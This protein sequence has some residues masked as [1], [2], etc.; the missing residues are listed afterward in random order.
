MSARKKHQPEETVVSVFNDA[1][2][3]RDVE[4]RFL[5][6][7]DRHGYPEISKFPLRLALEEALVNA[8]KH[9]HR[10]L[11]DKPVSVSWRIDSR[12]ISLSI[13]DQG[14]GFRPEE[15]PDPTTPEALEKP[16]GRGLMLM[17]AYMSSV[18]YSPTG[19]R[20]TMVYEHP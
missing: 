5:E 11:P 15:V 19:N 18:E 8:F 20:V 16:S 7:V 9:G 13:E 12:R 4:R 6:E 14:P 10:N 3:R 1:E 2:Q 17:R